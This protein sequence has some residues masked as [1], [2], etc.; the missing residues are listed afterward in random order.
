M[1]RQVTLLSRDV[2]IVK[3]F[4]NNDAQCMYPQMILP[5]GA[6]PS[7]PSLESASAL[8]LRQGSS[9]VMAATGQQSG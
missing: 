8:I 1:L 6:G 2:V 5:L 9:G 4:A 3:T 7:D